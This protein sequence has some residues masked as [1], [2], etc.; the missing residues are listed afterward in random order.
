MVAFFIPKFIENTLCHEYLPEYWSVYISNRSDNFI[1]VFKNGEW[2]L[3]VKHKV[4]SELVEWSI[5]SMKKYIINNRLTVKD[6]YALHYE[7]LARIMYQ[8]ENMKVKEELLTE[9][10]TELF[11]LFHNHKKNIILKNKYMSGKIK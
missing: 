9:V 10:F 8:P 3:A 11:C 5:R 6:E 1:N 2:E 7:E 4:F